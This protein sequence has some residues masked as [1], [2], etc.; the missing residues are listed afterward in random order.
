M[1][2]PVP[3]L[4][5]RELKAFNAADGSS[6]FFN[7]KWHVQ[8]RCI[9]RYMKKADEQIGKAAND[10]EKGLFTKAKHTFQMIMSVQ[11]FCSAYRAGPADQQALDEWMKAWKDLDTFLHDKPD[12][13]MQCKY[14]WATHY[15][16]LCELP[17]CDSFPAELNRHRLLQRSLVTSS[18]EAPAFQRRRRRLESM[19]HV[20]WDGRDQRKTKRMEGTM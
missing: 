5:E 2:T 13:N 1:A 10:E 19:D 6:N 3:E 20:T 15:D 8:W 7:S 14:V 9:E 17:I 12:V 4:L 16:V 11:K 18:E